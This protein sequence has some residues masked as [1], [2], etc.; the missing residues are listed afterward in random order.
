M[1]FVRSKV[2]AL[3]CALAAAGALAGAQAASETETGQ[4]PTELVVAFNELDFELDP[5]RSIYSAEAQIFTA[6][7]EG[8]FNYDPYSLDPVK[9]ACRS[10]TRSQDGKTYTFTIREDAEWSDG[11]PL[12][13]R[14]FRDSWLRVLAPDSEADYAAFFDIIRGARDYRTEKSKNSSSVGIEAVSDKVLKVTL[15]SRS[16]YFTR[17]LCHHSFSPV[18]PSMVE[19]ADWTEAARGSPESFPVNGPYRLTEVSADG[20]K[21][22]ANPRYWDAESVLV[23]DLRFI[24]TDDDA[25]VTRRF[26][27]GGIHWLAGPMDIDTL[28]DR[29]S[30]QVNPMF[31]THYWFFD[32]ASTPWSDPLLRRALA[33]LLPWEEIRSEKQYA[34]PA[35]TLVLPYSGYQEAKGI[36]AADEQ[37]AARLLEASGHGGGAGILPALVILVP[38]TEDAKRVSKLMEE[39]WNTLPE[40]RVE[41]KIVPASRYF[42]LV[43]AGPSASGYTIAMTTWIG[44]FADP[45]AFLQMWTSDSNLND[46]GLADKEY[47]KL[48]SDAAAKEGTD[49]LSALAVAET[50]L[51]SEAA[52]LPIYHSLAANAID[53][54]Y[55]RGWYQNF[56]DIHPFKYLEFGE[57][58][59]RPNVAQ[60]TKGRSA[61]S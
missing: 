23:S 19:R 35:Q 13:A 10:Y 26:D 33:L 40:L 8:L 28:L 43:R 36:S 4:F 47:D 42:E 20:M 31:G 1:P 32:C 22:S 9:A 44:D 11:T 12:L 17:L 38:D 2:L 14:D 53:T 34:T 16:D 7:Y 21:L 51:L 50:K 46:A 29:D 39:A 5:H 57:R 18:H 54:E 55:V 48:L 27:D 30:I 41:R 61:G 3:A 52:V 58:R 15:T 24:F 6:I 25:D 49:R 59:I 37:E 56:L 45:L 60:A